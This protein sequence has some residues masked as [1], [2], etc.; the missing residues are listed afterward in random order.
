MLQRARRLLNRERQLVE[1]CTSGGQQPAPSETAPQR[2]G[3][4]VLLDLLGAGGM[5][6]VYRAR[7]VSLQ[8]EVA[9]KIL[10]D[11]AL[12]SPSIRL[13]FQREATITAALD[14]PNIVPVFATGEEHGRVYLAMK[15]LRGRSLDRLALPLSPQRAA[16]IGL[17]VAGALHAAHEVGVLHRDVK[18]ANI[19]VEN[20]VPYVLD[21][22]LARVAHGTTALTQANAAPGTLVYMAPEL[23]RQGTPIFDPRT[24]VYGLG[25]TLY[26]ALA[27]AP[28]FLDDLAVRTLRQV[29]FHDPP[30]LR[31]P[32]RHRDL[33]TIV[34]R[35]MEKDP[36]RRLHS[37][38]AMAE[39][40]QR[41]LDG[42]PIR[43]RPIGPA[44]RAWRLVRRYPVPAALLAA[45][46][47]SLTLLAAVLSNHATEL[48]DR[49]ARTLEQAH[50]AL[51]AGDT[52]QGRRGVAAM[53]SEWG[54]ASDL[55]TLERDLDAEQG[56][57]ALLTLMQSPSIHQDPAALR[58][59]IDT[60]PRDSAVTRSP[61]ARMAV[62]LADLMIAGGEP[63]AEIAPELAA[64]F[65]RTAAAVAAVVSRAD[66]VPALAGC[67]E[68]TGD[69]YDHLFAALLLRLAN[70]PLREQEAELQRAGAVA[71]AAGDAIRF[72]RAMILEGREAHSEAQW[73][74]EELATKPACRAVALAG[75]ARTAARQGRF[76]EA[77]GYLSASRRA[78]GELRGDFLRPYVVMSE[79]QV[80]LDDPARGETFR[81]RWHE[82]A[83]MLGH[84]AWYWLLG[85]YREEVDAEQE[86]SDD[87]RRA[88]FAAARGFFEH[89]LTCKLTSESRQ[90]LELAL[91]QLDW[92]VSPARLDTDAL[93]G[94]ASFDEERHR[95][96]ALADRA[97]S[98]ARASNAKGQEWRFA[99]D[100]LLVAAQ[101][102][103][104]LG[105]RRRG[106]ELLER[107][108]RDPR[109]PEAL[110][111][112]SYWTA[113]RVLNRLRD[114]AWFDPDDGAG[115]DPLDLAARLAL[116]RAQEVLAK[117]AQNDAVA[118]SV[119]GMAQLARFVCAYHLCDAPVAFAAAAD[120]LAEPTLA[121]DV[122]EFCRQAL[123]DGGIC[124]ARLWSGGGSIDGAVR[125][126]VLRVL[127][128]A[129]DGVRHAAASGRL[130]GKSGA[131]ILDAWAGAESLQPVRDPDALPAG[132]RA[133]WRDF[134]ADLRE[135]RRGFDGGR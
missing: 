41:Y 75:L 123:D 62:A 42:N 74:F 89:G 1:L 40:L 111:T 7:Q 126:R 26:E 16:R 71:G 11:E 73:E 122:G 12:A 119:A 101:A 91:L 67:R 53:R 118:A 133:A 4:F 58:A 98:L 14:H 51:A 60:I 13:R 76:D 115:A 46:V 15:L 105:D 29:L 83:T 81:Q 114:P 21:F 54:D 65:P 36:R 5:G 130:D 68:T 77:Y 96:A 128:R 57:Q 132:E 50:A 86:P 25:V 87:A 129:L 69:P 18:P 49:R 107:V 124:L 59:I 47:L 113:S 108:C 134:W 34:L 52:I 19:V 99:A 66:P 10:R 8:R 35:A 93:P 9:V 90:A 100:A 72:S 37:A 43:S 117:A 64:A 23:L 110:A 56:L 24:D 28:P 109:L 131:V 33:E 48:R 127:Q 39:E 94:D 106:W 120:L 102:S 116:E 85:G 45:V 104:A 82:S 112:F 125:A 30:P 20:D 61:R 121:A 88:R 2:I 44:E 95:L 63:R 3:D 103:R 80:L 32:G 38:A 135:V 92:N 78:L 84:R 55:R 70:Q 6:R 27:G 31:L 17:A 97:E 22:G 79:L